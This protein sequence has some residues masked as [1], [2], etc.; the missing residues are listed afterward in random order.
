MGTFTLTQVIF[1]EQTVLLLRYCGRRCSRYFI[2][3]QYKLKMLQF[4]PNVPSNF[5]W[6][7]SDAHSQMIH[8]LESILFIDRLDQTIWQTSES[9][10]ESV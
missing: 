8:S 1:C 3:M 9:V 7:M 4:I 2:L 10:L 6:A 5:L